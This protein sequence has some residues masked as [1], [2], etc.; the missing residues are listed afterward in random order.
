MKKKDIE[1]QYNETTLPPN[2]ESKNE[3]RKQFTVS[4][5]I[6]LPTI[7]EFLHFNN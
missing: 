4:D 1:K 3:I 6:S 7:Y 2:N 5:F